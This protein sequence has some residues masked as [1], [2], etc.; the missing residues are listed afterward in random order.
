M[1]RLAITKD[2]LS[3]FAKLDKR[4]QGAVQSV[5]A[6]FA[7]GRHGEAYLEKVPGSLDDRIRPLRVDGLWHGAVLAPESGDTYYLVTV[8]PLTMPP[9]TPPATGSASTRY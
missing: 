9:P 5:I 7:S 2:V 6:D 4:V 1:A 3:A 8:L